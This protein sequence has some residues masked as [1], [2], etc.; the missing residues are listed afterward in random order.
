MTAPSFPLDVTPDEATAGFTLRPIGTTPTG[1]TVRAVST[2]LAIGLRA[3]KTRRHDGAIEYAIWDAETNAPIYTAA[4]DLP[5]LLRRF[6][7]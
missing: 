7:R 6:P 2:D 3:V 5:E 4:R 1:V